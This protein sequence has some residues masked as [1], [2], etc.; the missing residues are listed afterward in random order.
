V[1]NTLAQVVPM[2]LNFSN[3]KKYALYPRQIVLLAASHV[4]M[5]NVF[6]VLLDLLS[7]KNYLIV[8]VALTAILR[9]LMEF[10]QNLLTHALHFLIVSSVFQNI[11]SHVK[12]A[13]RDVL[14]N[15]N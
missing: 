5:I 10:A 11:V 12:L 8:L 3:S 2:V 14:E 13:F 15:K 4:Q 1:I 9:I 7:E 6:N